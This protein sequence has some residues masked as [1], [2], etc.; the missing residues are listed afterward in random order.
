MV[1]AFRA[2]GG[3]HRGRAMRSE[4]HTSELQ[5]QSNLV[6]RLLLEKKKKIDHDVYEH[7][8]LFCR[9]QGVVFDEHVSKQLYRRLPQRTLQ[10]STA[11]LLISHHALLYTIVTL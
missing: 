10:F 11:S 1:R 7:I 9:L 5:S 2:H 6:C 4:E 8:G 3:D